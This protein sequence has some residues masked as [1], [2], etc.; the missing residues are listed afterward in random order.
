MYA[1]RQQAEPSEIEGT[2]ALRE[3]GRDTAYERTHGRGQAQQER[4]RE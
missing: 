2:R 3:A 4:E 1:G